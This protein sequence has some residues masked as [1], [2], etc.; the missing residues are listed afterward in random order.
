MADPLHL[1]A[2]SNNERAGDSVLT[3]SLH[4]RLIR[5]AILV[6]SD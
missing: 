5:L 3:G 6:Q 4:V 2:L 1:A